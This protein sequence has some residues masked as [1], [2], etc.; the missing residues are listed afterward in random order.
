MPPRVAPITARTIRT[1]DVDRGVKRWFDKV[2]DPWASSPDGSR[3][4][5]PIKFSAGERWVASAD[6]QALRDRNGQLILPVIHISR[7]SFDPTGGTTALGLGVPRLQVARQISP[8]TTALA[9]LDQGRPISQRR[10]RD[11][12]VYEIVTVPFPLTGQMNY[13]TTIQA[14]SMQQMNEITEKILSRLEF[15]DVP[16]FVVSLTADEKNKP[17]KTGDG[18]TELEAHSEARYSERTPLTDYYFVG[19]LDGDWGNDGN[20]D[21]FT[22][23]ER[24]IELTFG[25][26][27]P[28]A[29]MLDPDGTKP[30]VQ[31]EQTAFGIKMGDEEVHF[32]DD[33]SDLDK[34]FG[35]K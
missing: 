35:L 6:R 28:V 27:V 21:E 25:F 1:E 18:S 29:L 11:S 22:D 19:Y 7:T 10:L 3:K 4:K 33:P 23:Q 14:S 26:R 32:V 5:V 30:A 13:E 20:L 12:A 31:V 2:A 17:L 16:S 8:K 34:I 15:F 9:N 24:I